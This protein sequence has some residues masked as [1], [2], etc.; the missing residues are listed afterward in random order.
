[1]L[2]FFRIG[3][4]QETLGNFIHLIPPFGLRAKHLRTFLSSCFRLTLFGV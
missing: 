4:E 1:M 2:G 3:H